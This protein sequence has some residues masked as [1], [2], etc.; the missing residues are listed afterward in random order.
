MMGLRDD[1]G[2][3]QNRFL[4]HPRRSQEPNGQAIGHWQAVSGKISSQHYHRT[5]FGTIAQASIEIAPLA[6]NTMTA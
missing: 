1:Y 2:H 6:L 4:T 3:L 5:I